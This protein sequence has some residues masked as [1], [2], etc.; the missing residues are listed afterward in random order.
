MNGIAALQIRS[1]GK[2]GLDV[3]GIDDGLCEEILLLN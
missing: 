3:L 1:T 2:V